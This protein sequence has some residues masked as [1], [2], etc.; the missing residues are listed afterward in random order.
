MFNLLYKVESRFEHDSVTYKKAINTFVKQTDKIN[1]KNDAAIQK[2]LFTFA[3]DVLK[4]VKKDWRTN[5]GFIPV[6]STSKSRRR[7]KHRGTG[8]I[9]QGRPTSEQSQKLQLEVNDEEEILYYTIPRRNKA[10]RKHPHSLAKSVADNRAS[11]K[12]TKWG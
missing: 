3:K 1:E 12:W 5:S 4:T 9:I 6:Q 2:A 7:I 8:P 10:K 11:E